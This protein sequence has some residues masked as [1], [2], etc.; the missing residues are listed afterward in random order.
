MGRAE[1]VD[2]L[3]DEIGKVKLGMSP[4][5]IKKIAV[6][7]VVC[8][9][10]MISDQNNYSQEY[11][12]QYKDVAAVFTKKLQTGRFSGELQLQPRYLGQYLPCRY[13]MRSVT[14]AALRN[15][16][17]KRKNPCFS[18]AW[19][20]VVY[21]GSAQ[22]LLSQYYNSPTRICSYSA[23]NSNLGDS[24]ATVAQTLGLGQSAI[25]G[26]WS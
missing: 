19:R 3:L 10:K 12:L 18:T 21:H 26:M 2:E 8:S 22:V 24:R 7:G 17:R 9:P 11:T 23:I 20:C 13:L 6:D 15:K 4:F 16:L 1:K 5:Q 14:P 25:V